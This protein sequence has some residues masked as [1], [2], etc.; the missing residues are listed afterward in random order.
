MIKNILLSGKKKID[1]LIK[2]AG[3]SILTNMV[4]VAHFKWQVLI[5]VLA[6]HYAQCFF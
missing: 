3:D 2:Y 1:S 4:K 5:S 6:T